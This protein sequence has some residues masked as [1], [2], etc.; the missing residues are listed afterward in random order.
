MA[1][2]FDKFIPKEEPV[3]TGGIDFGKFMPK[4]Y[5]PELPIE[6]KEDK[7]FRVATLPDFL[8]GG[9][10]NVA[11]PGELVK[12]TRGYAGLPTK[13]EQERDH[14]ISVALGGTS[15][16]DNVEYKP[17]P[18]GE[19]GKYIYELRQG[20]KV[21][22]EEKVIQDYKDGKIGLNEARLK[23]L[24]KQQD[25]EAEKLGLS[26][27]PYSWT[28][29][30]G[31]IKETF[32]HPVK[33]FKEA[34]KATPQTQ[35][36]LKAI[37]ESFK[38]TPKM[39][40]YNTVPDFVNSIKKQI[41]D[42][43]DRIADIF[44][45][46]TETK[47]EKAAQL[48]KGGTGVVST[49]ISP[50]TAFFEAS[51]NIPVVGTITSIIGLPFGVIGDTATNITN[52][53]LNVLSEKG[54]VDPETI[55]TLREALV[56]VNVLASQIAV[57]GKVFKKSGE[58]WNKKKT[59]LTKKYGK[60]DAKTIME[61]AE[62]KAKAEVKEAKPKIDFDKFIEKPKKVTKKAEPI[63]QEIKLK[64][65]EVKELNKLDRQN[66]NI[67][68]RIPELESNKV[69]IYQTGID[70]G[71]TIKKGS[72]IDTS[73]KEHIARGTKNESK[74]F[75]DITETELKNNFTETSPGI[76]RALNEMKGDVYNKLPQRLEIK[77]IEEV[78][79]LRPTGTATASIARSIERKA[80]EKGLRDERF[81][82]LATFERTT[83]KD[84]ARAVEQM[85]KSDFE[86][87]RRVIRG[88]EPL[89]EGV[90]G[91]SLVKGM[92]LIIKKT[93]DPELA[94]ELANSPHASGLSLAAQE[95]S[96]ARGRE[97]DSATA[98][99]EKVRKAREKKAGKDIEKKSQIK[100]DIKKETKKNNLS[101]EDLKWDNFLDKI[102]C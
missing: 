9:S 89:P 88:E 53:T 36:A 72:Y 52:E 32:G 39:A 42:A 69:R 34:V 46:P 82:T 76:Y 47:A 67:T 56:E 86:K 37:P 50:V 44:V 40:A 23:V 3:K 80:I 8:G 25:I 68:K 55:E 65:K 31:G 15:N 93:K 38:A 10:Y 33:T 2:N 1:I 60:K 29:I 57:G 90:R 87:T 75:K 6:V 98:R 45:T 101:K 59:E 13:F 66:Y 73:L 78:K 64:P 95:M 102:K 20:G 22:V 41:E 99:T 94:Y 18:K 81:D 19:D 62:V 30:W 16:I 85:F 51:K 48:I 100:K 24:G 61:K 77:P 17:S 71:G 70:H 12:T 14:I 4:S 28:N 35:E 83:L 43:G 21:V 91:I 92:E 26:K 96:L 58:L 49:L 5:E 7:P 54:I 27:D 63:K 84:Q 97:L 11:E 79:P 74:V